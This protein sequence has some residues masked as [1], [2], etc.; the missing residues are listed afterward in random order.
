MK[1]FKITYLTYKT[2]YASGN[3]FA[4]AEDKFKKWI[5]KVTGYS[6]LDIDKIELIS[7]QLIQ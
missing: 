6:P 1:L 3:D 5:E 2:I 7:D 4:E